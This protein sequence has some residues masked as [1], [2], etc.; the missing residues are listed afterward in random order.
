MEG[1]PKLI[2]VTR[3]VKLILDQSIDPDIQMLDLS[4]SVLVAAP[5]PRQDRTSNIQVW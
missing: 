2:N 3:A 1:F 4:C 5:I